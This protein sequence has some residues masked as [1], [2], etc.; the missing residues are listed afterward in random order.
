MPVVVHYLWDV[1]NS[2]LALRER[3]LELSEP[4][5]PVLVVWLEMAL[6]GPWP[7]L[8]LA[9]EEGR[10]LQSGLV[11]KFSMKGPRRCPR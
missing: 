11:C 5:E 8:Y 6:L 10:K 7:V 9:F 4:Q 2:V 1:W 3:L